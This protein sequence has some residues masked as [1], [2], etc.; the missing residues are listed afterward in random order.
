METVGI[1]PTDRSRHC[2][3]I[4][5]DDEFLPLYVGITCRF[6]ERVSNHKR[7]KPWWDRVAHVEV[8]HLAT[9]EAARARELE[10]IRELDPPYN[11][12]GKVRTESWG[13]FQCD[14]QDVVELQWGSHEAAVLGVADGS[15]DLEVPDF[16]PDQ[17]GQHLYC[18]RCHDYVDIDVRRADGA[19]YRLS[20]DAATGKYRWQKLGQDSPVSEEA[21]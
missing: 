18:R 14:G 13:C 6:G 4:F 9:R 3:Y 15:P 7:E 5:R 8:Q 21:A 11:I 16:V 2:V 17:G 10:L 20:V 12:E 19:F 1:E